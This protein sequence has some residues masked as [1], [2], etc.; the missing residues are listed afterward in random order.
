MCEDSLEPK[1]MVHTSFSILFSFLKSGV[2][3]LDF[4]AGRRGG[5]GASS[6][7]DEISITSAAIGWGTAFCLAFVRFAGVWWRGI[8]EAGTNSEEDAAALATEG[9]ARIWASR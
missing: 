9:P 1:D 4:A 2:F 5:G 6:S 3:E 7:S 8:G